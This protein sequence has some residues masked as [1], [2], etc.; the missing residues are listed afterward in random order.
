MK[1]MTQKVPTLVYLSFNKQLLSNY[2]VLGTIEDA[3]RTGCKDVIKRNG[4]ST[5]DGEAV[6][7]REAAAGLSR[8]TGHSGHPREGEEQRFPWHRVFTEL[9]TAQPSRK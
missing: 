7:D 5:G 3:R 6:A 1:D 8:Q 4:D 2:C 9:Q